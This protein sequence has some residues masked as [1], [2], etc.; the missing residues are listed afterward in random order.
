MSLS[1]GDL[2]LSA[3]RLLWAREHPDELAVTDAM[4]IETIASSAID[5]FDKYRASVN[6][7]RTLVE[8]FG[9]KSRIKPIVEHTRVEMA[10]QLCHKAQEVFRKM[11]SEAVVRCGE[12][13]GT[14]K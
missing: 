5:A 3:D 11:S 14:E 13:A 12:D 10:R 8:H 4:T 1:V 2:V 9:A 6:N 7:Y